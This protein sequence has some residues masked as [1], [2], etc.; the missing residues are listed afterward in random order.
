M[1]AADQE[2]PGTR[3]AAG[4]TY[5]QWFALLDQWGAPGRPFREIADWLE[6]E[7]DLSRWWAQKLIVDYEQARGLRPPGVRPDGTF[8]V[9]AGKTVSVAVDRLYAA[10]VDPAERDRWL[11]GTVLR[12]RTSRPYRSARFD[13]GDGSRVSV[14]F[15]AKGD[16]RSTLALEHERLPDAETATSTKAFWRERLT[17]LKAELERATEPENG[18]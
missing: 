4:R 16:T 7:H 12:E 13:R 14:T 18:S 5:D 9:G 6:G 2:R 1:T 3:R 15:Q 10:V 11:P 17:V 8:T